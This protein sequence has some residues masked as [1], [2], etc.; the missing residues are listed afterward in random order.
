[1]TAVSASSLTIAGNDGT[2]H[3][4][5]LDDKTMEPGQAAKQNDQVVVAAI[6]GSSTATAVIRVDAHGPFAGPHGPWGR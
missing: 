5:A 3:T 1:V 2:A 6:S 4:Y